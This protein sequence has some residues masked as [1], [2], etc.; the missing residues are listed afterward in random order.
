MQALSLLL[1]VRGRISRAKF[2]IGHGILLVFVFGLLLLGSVI[3]FAIFYIDGRSSLF[4]A[5]WV[6]ITFA[7]LVWAFVTLCIKRF[8]DHDSSG[9]WCLILLVPAVGL[10]F[11]FIELGMVRGTSGR[12]DY[13]PDPLE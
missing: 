3:D 5:I 8:H 7:L 4:V 12:N 10:F 9:W 13:G 6:S 2:W 1:D 11:Y